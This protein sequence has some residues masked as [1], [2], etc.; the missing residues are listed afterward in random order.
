MDLNTTVVLY[1]AV[2]NV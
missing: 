1:K 2:N